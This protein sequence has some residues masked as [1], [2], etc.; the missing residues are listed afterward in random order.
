MPTQS[1]I[2]DQFK[3]HGKIDVP[4]DITFNNIEIYSGKYSAGGYVI[5]LPF[6]GKSNA[7]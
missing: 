4:L 5:N 1:E 7:T 2:I 6:S 3:K